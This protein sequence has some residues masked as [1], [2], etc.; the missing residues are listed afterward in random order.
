MR[1]WMLLCFP[2]WFERK[3]VAPICAAAPPPPATFLCA[4]KACPCVLASRLFWKIFQ[5]FLCWVQPQMLVS[6][7]SINALTL[8]TIHHNCS[9]KEQVNWYPTNIMK[10]PFFWNNTLTQFL[11]PVFA[12]KWLTSKSFFMLISKEKKKKV[13]LESFFFR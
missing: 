9:L 1:G 7:Y 8:S 12:W 13:I 10:F 3:R 5:M 4:L 6:I 11:S 2:H